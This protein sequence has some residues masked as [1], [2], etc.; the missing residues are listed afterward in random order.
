MTETAWIVFRTH[1]SPDVLD[2]RVGQ[3][4]APD[5]W[6]A[7]IEA[8]AR[9]AGPLRVQSRLSFEAER[10]ECS[11]HGLPPRWCDPPPAPAPAAPKPKPAPIAKAPPPS[12][13]LREELRRQAAM[14]AQATRA[15]KAAAR[16]AALIERARRAQGL[17]P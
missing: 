2:V 11:A 12:D 8:I 15:E 4:V 17:D 7:E 1:P 14:R 16:R 13:A 10:E 6:H 9:W 5:R 3:V